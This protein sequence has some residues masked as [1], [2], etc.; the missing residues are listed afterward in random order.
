MRDAVKRVMAAG[1]KH[2]IAVGGP[3]GSP[4]A[5]QRMIGEGYRFIQGPSEL[6][7]M[8]VAL[9]DFFGGLK[10]AGVEKKDPIPLY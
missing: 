9:R 6:A 7:L 10:S 3:G 4:A 1:K 5:I 2:N 8:Q